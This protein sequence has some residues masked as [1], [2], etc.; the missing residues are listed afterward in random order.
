MLS[1]ML[2]RSVAYPSDKKL[3]TVSMTGSQICALLQEPSIYVDQ[4]S[5]RNTSYFVASGLKIEFAPWRDTDSR[6]VLVT[7]ADGS[8][9]ESD[10]TYTVALW[11]WPFESSCPYPVQHVYDETCD[12]V[13]GDAVA[14][15]GTI[16]PIADDRF[17]LVWDE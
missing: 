10:K 2:G 12:Q 13:I 15:Q 1:L 9:L 11:A 14:Q 6:V 3:W 7:L 5:F 17:T 4:E 16:S 8:P